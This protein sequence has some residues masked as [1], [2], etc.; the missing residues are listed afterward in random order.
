MF[1]FFKYEVCW[2]LIGQT[3][4]NIKPATEGNKKLKLSPTLTVRVRLVR[5]RT[6]WCFENLNEATPLINTDRDFNR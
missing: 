2:A 1:C 4:S 5:K 6:A 3:D